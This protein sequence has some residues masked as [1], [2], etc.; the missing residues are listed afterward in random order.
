MLVTECFLES[1]MRLGCHEELQ[2]G[3]NVKIYIRKVVFR[4]PE[5]VLVFS[6]LYREASIRSR[7][8]PDESVSPPRVPPRPKG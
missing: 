5:K 4:V 2:N 1:R 6:V 8:V 3:T 7:K